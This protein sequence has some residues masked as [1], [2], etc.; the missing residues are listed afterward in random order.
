[1]AVVQIAVGSLF[2][3]QGPSPMT[4]FILNWLAES[5]MMSLPQRLCYHKTFS[6]NVLEQ[7]RLVAHIKQLFLG[8]LDLCLLND[9]GLLRVGNPIAPSEQQSDDES[10][11]TKCQTQAKAGVVFWLFRLEVHE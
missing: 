8:V 10:T 1:M 3:L 2:P 5:L 7:W 9:L 6:Q 4:G 11:A